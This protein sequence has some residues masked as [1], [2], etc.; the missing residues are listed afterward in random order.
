M[1][2]ITFFKTLDKWIFIGNLFKETT[3]DR[4]INLSP[5]CMSERERKR[6]LFF[7]KKKVEKVEK[8]KK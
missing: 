5:L 3:S 1:Y 6:S 4:F 7:Y 8:N 2:I